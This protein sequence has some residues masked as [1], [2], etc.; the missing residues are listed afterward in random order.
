MSAHAY[1]RLNISAT[2]TTDFYFASIADIQFKSQT[3]N[4][5][6]TGATFFASSTE[7]VGIREPFMAFD[8]KKDTL[9][10]S[11][12][13]AGNIGPAYIGAQFLSPVDVAEV[14]LTAGDSA[15]RAARMPTAF[16]LEYSD[17]GTTWTA[18]QSYSNIAPFA[19]GSTVNVGTGAVVTGTTGGTTGG[20]GSTVTSS[21]IQSLTAAITQAAQ[22]AGARPDVVQAELLVFAAALVA[23]SCIWAAKR[24]YVLLTNGAHE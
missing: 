13:S 19:P 10:A 16:T 18:S 8:N 21:D 9:W 7:G 24:L 3:G 11:A 12:G 1:W 5:A 23:V 14:I 2:G 4:I 22:S 20:T 6:N 15:L 17:N